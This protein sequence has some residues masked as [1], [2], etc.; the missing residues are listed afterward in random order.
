MAKKTV[1]RKLPCIGIWNR[2]ASCVPTAGN[3]LV[4]IWQ[5]AH[6]DR[7]EFFCAFFRN[8]AGECVDPDEEDWVSITYHTRQSD[9]AEFFDEEI[10]PPDYW[11]ECRFLIPTWGDAR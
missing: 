9:A 2:C 7:I 1:S 10:E 4:G 6:G 11:A 5:D 3:T 8:A